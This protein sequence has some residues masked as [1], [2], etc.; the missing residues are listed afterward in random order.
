MT[1]TSIKAMNPGLNCANL[2]SEYELDVPL[3]CLSGN[4]LRVSAQIEN[5]STAFKIFT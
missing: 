1:L 2:H 3:C 5:G 4:L